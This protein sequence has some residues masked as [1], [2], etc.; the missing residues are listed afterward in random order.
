MQQSYLHLSL[1]FLNGSYH[2]IE[3]FLKGSWNLMGNVKFVQPAPG[4]SDSK[5]C[6]F[7]ILVACDRDLP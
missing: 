3:P 7:G 1:E 5:E 2:I 6:H 4:L